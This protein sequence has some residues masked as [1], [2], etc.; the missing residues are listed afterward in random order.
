MA[1]ELGEN[2]QGISSRFKG[3][4]LDSQATGTQHSAIARALAHIF[5]EDINPPTLK[6]KLPDPDERL[7][8]TR[9]LVC[10]L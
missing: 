9:Q 10:C 5:P 6:L 3:I 1:G 2:L 4:S 7:Q 8:S